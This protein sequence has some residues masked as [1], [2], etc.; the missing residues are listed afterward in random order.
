VEGSPPDP[1][2]W[3]HVLARLGPLRTG[4][5]ILAGVALLVPLVI[6]HLGGAI[7]IA[8]LVVALLT[9]TLVGKAL[10]VRRR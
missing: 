4:L 10:T 3:A 5:Y 9:W 1:T 2:G 7:G 8:F 6:F